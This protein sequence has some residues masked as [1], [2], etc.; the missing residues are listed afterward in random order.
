MSGDEDDA[1]TGQFAGQRHRLVGV[2]EV[3]ADDELDPLAEDAA[4]GVEILYR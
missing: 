2:A 3:V 1:I 4:P